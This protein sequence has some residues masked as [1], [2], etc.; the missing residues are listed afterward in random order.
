MSSGVPRA[1]WGR[2]PISELC[3]ALGLVFAVAGLATIGSDRGFWLLAA[4]MAL[5]LL[6]GVELAAR[7]H[8]GGLRRRSGLLACAVAAG[9]VAAAALGGLP[10][11]ALVP[12]GAVTFGLAFVALERTYVRA[13][14]RAGSAIRPQDC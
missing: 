1:P 13:R 12:A 11:L 4:A 10:G 7:E 8:F 6:A 9:A 5:A 14:D 3:V 2:A